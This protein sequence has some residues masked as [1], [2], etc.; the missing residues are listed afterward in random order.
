MNQRLETT[1]SIALTVSAVALAG[2][3]V[4]RQVLATPSDQMA[5]PTYVDNWEYLV[6]SGSRIGLSEA[7]VQIVE[8]GDFQC[9]FCRTFHN[10]VSELMSEF[11]DEVSLVYH[12][13]PLP[14][15]PRVRPGTGHVRF[16][17][18]LWLVRVGG[19]Y[20]TLT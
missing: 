4:Y 9:P 19:V 5:K 20:C 6:N 17:S 15:H 16:T 14:Q 13:F 12:H 1:L 18:Q 2:T 7:P 10:S 11:P 8:F 3:V